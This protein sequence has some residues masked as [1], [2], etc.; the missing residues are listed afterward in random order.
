MPSYCR[1]RLI[2]LRGTVEPLTVAVHAVSVAQPE[3][4]A[5]VVVPGAGLIGQ[6][7]IQVLK[8]RKSPCSLAQVTWSG[9]R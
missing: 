9:E 6:R 4:G 3:L 8:A 2:L 1:R 5:N 7:V